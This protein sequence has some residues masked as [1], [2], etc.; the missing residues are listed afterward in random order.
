MAE[1]AN[2]SLLVV[3]L[4]ESTVVRVRGCEGVCGGVRVLLVDVSG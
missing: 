4:N 2:A 3:V 1:D